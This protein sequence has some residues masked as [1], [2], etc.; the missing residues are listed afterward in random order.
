MSPRHGMRSGLKLAV[1]AIALLTAACG[2]DGD[3]SSAT[4]PG[5]SPTTAASGNFPAVDEPV[6]TTGP[7]TTADEPDL[8]DVAV[9]VSEV[10]ALESPTALAIRPGSDTL[11]VTER[12]GR[13]QALSVA[14]GET[15]KVTVADEP[16]LDISEEVSTSGEQ[17]L[18]GLAFSADGATSYV[19]FTNREGDTRLVSY[20]MD[21]DEFSTADRR[22]LLAV[23]QPFANHNGGNVEVGPDGLVYFGLGD[24][25]SGDDPDNRA[26]N[27]DDLLGKMLRIDPSR[28]GDG[29]TPYA[30]PEGN[31]FRDGGGR[32]EIFLSGV[33]N[34]W[35]FSFDR[36]TGDLW[37]GDVGQVSIEE[38]DF[39]EKGS[40]A[41]LDL[42]WSGYEGTQRHIEDR[43]VEPSTPPIFEMS[44]DDGFCSVTGGVVYRGERIPALTGAYL[45]G[46]Y[47]KADLQ[48]LRQADGVV[49]DQRQLDT[50]VPDLVSIEEDGDG[51]IWLLSLSGGLYRL[52]PA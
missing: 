4:R 25:G 13:I 15:G 1:L 7:S 26:P 24:G 45:Y 43:I 30:I 50:Q 16:L 35:R 3:D 36:E 48:V 38:I 12:V 33:R 39:L 32:P 5:G 41:G 28:P 27:P 11:F 6:T 49:F 19:S 42:G 29:D 46:D 9:R 44:H 52:D 17:G 10:A 31:P 47:C 23:D 51:E 14:D 2:S 18:L 34:P 20:A 37:I 22:Q 21:G 8:A 40:G